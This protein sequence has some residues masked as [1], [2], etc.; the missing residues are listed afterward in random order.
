MLQN[1]IAE[2]ENKPRQNKTGNPCDLWFKNKRISGSQSCNFSAFLLAA[3]LLCIM[4]YC[5]NLFLNT[6]GKSLQNDVYIYFGLNT[7][8]F[9]PPTHPNSPFIMGTAASL[10]PT[11]DHQWCEIPTH[12]LLILGIQRNSHKRGGR[13]P[14]I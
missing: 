11:K 12:T 2:H 7:L 10:K 14:Q 3:L 1:K 13:S 6:V 8:Y 9:C 4:I 5:F